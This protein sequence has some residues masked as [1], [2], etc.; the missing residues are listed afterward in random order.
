MRRRG[1]LDACASVTCVAALVMAV[2][3]PEAGL[4]EEPDPD[5]WEDDI[6]A[7]EAADRASPPPKG[8]VLFVGSSSIR[9]WKL[10]QWFPE[11][12]AINR[13]FG[14]SQIADVN[15]YVERIVLPYT[16]A[17]IVFYAGDNDINAK[18]PPE[19]V[20]ADFRAFVDRVHAVLPETEVL[21]IAIKPSLK[22]W[23]QFA[24]QQQ[25]ND[26]IRGFCEADDRLSY[27]DIVAPMLGEN[28]EPRPELFDD[29]GLHLNDAG[30][31]L[32]TSRVASVLTAK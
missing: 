3:V 21:F 7:F 27:L 8:A 20:A 12:T 22:R 2:A 30:Y 14:G 31:A 6:A 13:G 17:Q 32:W 18:K 1:F 11:L 16:P 9:L 15:R 25:A 28:G 26:S 5:K 19:Q 4:A 23:E 24:T 29:D 10:S